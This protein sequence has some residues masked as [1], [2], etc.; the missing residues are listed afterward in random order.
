MKRIAALL[1]AA[2]LLTGCAVTGQ[3]ANPDVA[4]T[5]NGN[6]ITNTEADAAAQ[7][8]VGMSAAPHPGE[9]I[10]LLLLAPTALEYAA[11]AGRTQDPAAGPS[12]VQLWMAANKGEILEATPDQVEVVAIV[13]AIAFML[14]EE[15]GVLALTELAVDI[16]AHAV[17]SPEYGDFSAETFLAS[18]KSAI[19]TAQKRGETLGPVAYMVFKDING[20]SPWAATEWQSTDS[21]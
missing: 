17:V 5:Y 6:V 14:S 16:E 1:T 12:E 7:A 15:E 10:T 18:A 4:A 21:E 19:D 9:E 11:E 3:E 2:L 8:L 13:Q 20:F